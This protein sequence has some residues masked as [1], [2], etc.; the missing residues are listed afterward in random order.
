MT[1]RLKD[2]FDNEVKPSLMKKFRKLEQNK[3]I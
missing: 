2:R 3:E 1:S